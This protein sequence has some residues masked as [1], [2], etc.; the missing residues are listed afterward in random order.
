MDGRTRRTSRVATSTADRARAFGD[1]ITKDNPTQRD[2]KNGFVKG[3][4]EGSRRAS[5]E[6]ASKALEDAYERL[7]KDDHDE[8]EIYC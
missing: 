3:T 7:P 4:V 5:L 2:L 1:A 8:S 6:S